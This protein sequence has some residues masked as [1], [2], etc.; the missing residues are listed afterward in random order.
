M[1]HSFN[2]WNTWDNKRIIHLPK[3]MQLDHTTEI[4]AM[5]FHSRL[6]VTPYSLLTE[7]EL[8][9]QFSRN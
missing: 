1:M 8:E 6:S 9:P 7:M 3:G 4:Q 2:K 5:I